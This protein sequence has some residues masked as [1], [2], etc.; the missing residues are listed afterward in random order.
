MTFIKLLQGIG[1]R[2]GILESV[3]TVETTRVTR[4]QTRI[5]SLRELAGEIHSGEVQALADSPAE[6]DIPFEKIFEAAGIASKPEDW[7]VDRLKQVIAGE[8]GKQKS[9]E[10]VQKSVLKLLASEGVPVETLVKDAMAR[11]QALD[12]FESRVNEKMQDRRKVC[13]KRL[14]EIELQIKDLREE[15]A[16]L[17]AGLKTDEGKWHNWKKL[18][19][20]REQDL[21]STASYIIDHP[22]IT[23]DD[24]D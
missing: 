14:L 17:E 22:V 1:D 3:E 15:S 24:E 5:V 11:D 4:I 7:T 19:R 23:T 20:A 6:L 16:R 18:K 10:E 21:A 13:K 12:S 8:T 2:L 9:H